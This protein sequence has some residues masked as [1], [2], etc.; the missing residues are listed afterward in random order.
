MEITGWT[1]HKTVPALRK[2]MKDDQCPSIMAL[3]NLLQ[4]PDKDIR[5]RT[6][7]AARRAVYMLYIPVV[8]CQTE[9]ETEKN[10]K[11]AMLLDTNSIVQRKPGNG[12]PQ[13]VKRN[14]A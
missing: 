9:K 14:I 1:G 7:K 13:K 8:K 12:R 6:G 3:P 11:E 2:G 10:I 5:A 4:N